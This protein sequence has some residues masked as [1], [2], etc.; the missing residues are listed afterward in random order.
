MNSTKPEDVPLDIFALDVDDF[1]SVDATSALGAS[2]AVRRRELASRTPLRGR[3]ADQDPLTIVG[4]S[5]HGKEKFGEALNAFARELLASR[6]DATHAD[7]E[8]RRR[9]PYKI[10]FVHD[11]DDVRFLRP[12]DAMIFVIDPTD[13]TA[14]GE[15]EEFA[16]ALKRIGLAR[17]MVFISKLD[18]MADSHKAEKARHDVK[19]LL[20]DAGFHSS[21]VSLHFGS[22]RGAMRA[23][24]SGG[25]IWTDAFHG[26]VRQ[27]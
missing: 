9:D 11:V 13:A 18:L 10:T 19:E 15:L 25:S 27:L 20:G 12:G 14:Q 4:V 1:D 3:A 17:L 16:R 5:G 6:D 23:Q 26:V 7:I 2:E 24:F 22:A 21:Q 8:H